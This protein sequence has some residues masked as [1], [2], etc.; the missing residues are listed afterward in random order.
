MT[1]V[2]GYIR[3]AGL[4]VCLISTVLLAPRGSVADMVRVTG[5]A[6]IASS[7]DTDAR[8]RALE[9]A[10]YL[11]ALEGGADI[12]GF[13][14]VDKGVM[15]GES[16]L[17]RP[18]S[19]IL[20]FA[21]IDEV[22]AHSF[23]EVTIEA[24]VGERPDLGCAARPDIVL[25]AVHPRLHASS[26]TPL[27]MKNALGMAHERTINDLGRI[28]KIKIVESDV[29]LHA[30]APSTSRVRPGFDYQTLLTGRSDAQTPRGSPLPSDAR[31]LHFQWSAD[32][33]TVGA[34]EVEVTLEA[35]IIDQASSSR[36]EQIRFRHT[37]KLTPGTPWRALNVVARKDQQTV[38]ATLSAHM[39]IGLSSWLVNFA[40]AP[41][42]ANLKPMGEGRFRVPLGIRDGL[43]RQSLAFAEGRGQPWTV[44]RIVDLGQSSALIAPMNASSA[45]QEMSG[46]QVRFNAGRE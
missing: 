28:A 23:Y 39:G 11:A 26:S 4:L 6:V 42:T 43:T 44:F 30:A 1:Y 34:N 35:R 32:A 17:L 31:A 36:E 38:A 16:I 25:T 37:V 10:L 20:D 22:K 40:C 9:D 7:D 12:E 21:V 24:Y 13:S 15:T 5:R 29:D 46:A 33:A 3:I 18:S 8:R 45:A 14:V 2:G 19:R 41:L 27:W